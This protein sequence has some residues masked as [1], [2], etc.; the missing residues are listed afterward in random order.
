MNWSGTALIVGFAVALFATA[1]TAESDL[2]SPYVNADE[3]CEGVFAGGL[4]ETVE[5]VTGATSFKRGAGGGIGQLIKKIEKGYASGRD[6]SPGGELC[7]MVSK[8]SGSRERTTLAFHIYAPQ[9]VNYPGSAEGERRFSLGKEAVANNRSAGIYFECVSPQLDGSENSPARIYG[10][11]SGARDRGSALQD[12]TNNI[13]VLH[14]AVLA[15]IEKLECE[16]GAGI[17]ERL[18]T[19]LR[20]LPS[21]SS[22]AE[23]ES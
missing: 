14:S 4:E 18:G 23:S 9:D 6:W 13:A 19:A 7:E 3:V 11:L 15:V 2:Q 21:L 20:E 5:T 22:Q 17:P 1:C 16:Q 8:G 10:G 12:L